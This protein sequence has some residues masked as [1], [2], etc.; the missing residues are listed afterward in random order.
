M[1]KTL[2]NQARKLY[3]LYSILDN[4]D[5]LKMKLADTFGDI[6][7]IDNTR[8]IINNIVQKHYPNE[9]IIKSSFINYITKNNTNKTIIYE[10]NVHNSRVDLC[11]I[12]KKSIAYEIKT[13][14]D[15]KNRLQKQINDYKLVFEENYLICSKQKLTSLSDSISPDV[16]IYLY[17]IKKSGRIYFSKFRP[18]K[19][20]QQ[21]N[22][23]KQLESLTKQE[24]KTIYNSK[25][26]LEKSDLISSILTKYQKK[27]INSFFKICI[28]QRYATR[29]N[30][31]FS[32]KDSIFLLDYQ[33]FYNNPINPTLIY[34]A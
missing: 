8:T 9:A 19:K 1:D 32:H 18:A 27:K 5:Q 10:M 33:W 29:W 20:N 3:S 25:N 30:F 2:T 12:G 28:K 15:T 16:G 6:E 34:Q 31:L 17:T 13:D 24:L 14:F 11:S 26:N 22:A 23:E 21:I 7:T 4:K